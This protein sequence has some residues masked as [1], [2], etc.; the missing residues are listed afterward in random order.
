MVAAV[1]QPPLLAEQGRARAC[2][3]CPH[4]RNAV[5]GPGGAKDFSVGF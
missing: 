4:E 1:M 3:A 2:L 5:L